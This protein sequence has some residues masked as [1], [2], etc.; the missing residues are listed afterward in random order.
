MRVRSRKRSSWAS[1]SAYVPSCSIG[2]CVATTRN[3]R[4]RRYVVPSTVTWRSCMASSSAA[5]V[6]AGA[7]FTSSPSTRLPKIGPGRKRNSPLVASKTVAPGDVRRQQVGRE[8]DAGEAEVRDLGQRAGGERLGHAGQVVQQHVAV[9]D[10]A[11]QHQLQH[12][13]L[14]HDGP[15]QLVEDAGHRRRGVRRA[16]HGRGRRHRALRPLAGLVPTG[17]S[18]AAS[19]WSTGAVRD[20]PRRNAVTSGPRRSAMAG[21][22]SDGRGRGRGGRGAPAPRRGRCRAAACCGAA[23]GRRPGWP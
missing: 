23:G 17:G 11:E 18:T 9:G 12:V 4:G 8:L 13:A 22:S 14:A 21:A 7:R 3:G 20:S 1:G 16:E 5:C 6:L 10:Q 19:S 2:F 15:L